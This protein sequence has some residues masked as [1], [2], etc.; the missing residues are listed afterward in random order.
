MTSDEICKPIGTGLSIKPF[1]KT[2]TGQQHK[3]ELCIL[4]TLNFLYLFSKSLPIINKNDNKTILGGPVNVEAYFVNVL[5]LDMI[6]VSCNQCQ[7]CM[8]IF[9]SGLDFHTSSH[10]NCFLHKILKCMMPN[11][12]LSCVSL[13][14][15]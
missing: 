8:F 2:D 7:V 1:T 3:W 13:N 9:L 14:R 11:Y 6:Y 5:K 15:L 4:L 10:V 12:T